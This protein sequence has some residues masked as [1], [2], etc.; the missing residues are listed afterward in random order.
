VS[1]LGAVRDRSAG[2]APARILP[3]DGGTPLDPFLDFFRATHDGR[4]ALVSFDDAARAR[5]A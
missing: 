4:E 5:G 3:R 2:I 1:V